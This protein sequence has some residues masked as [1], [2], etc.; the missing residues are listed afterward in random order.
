MSSE[1]NVNVLLKYEK[2]HF[3]S[4]RNADYV[5]VA[6]RIQTLPRDSAKIRVT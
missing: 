2:R 3:K 4:I 5:S 1:K 6:I